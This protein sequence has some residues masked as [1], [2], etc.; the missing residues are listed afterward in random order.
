[1]KKIK[2]LYCPYCHNLMWIVDDKD[3]PVVC[4]G[5]EMEELIANTIDAVKE[6]HVPVVVEKD[7]KY[8]VKI[9]SEAH[10]MTNDHYIMWVAMET[11]GGITYKYLQPD[12][13][14]EVT[15]DPGDEKPVA[16]YAYCNIHRLWK[17]EM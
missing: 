1:M 2:F 6:K 4:C 8:T 16:F 11:K 14:P 15:F 13:T 17:K 10:P 7:G 9:G 5:E 3:V 12:A